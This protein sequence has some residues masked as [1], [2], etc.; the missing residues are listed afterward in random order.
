MKKQKSYFILIGAVFVITV[1]LC[2]V[3]FAQGVTATWS[4]S[5]TFSGGSSAT[6]MIV[7]DSGPIRPGDFTGIDQN[8]L[9]SATTMVVEITL[10]QV[11]TG[12]ASTNY[13]IVAEA[14]AEG[15]GGDSI[16]YSGTEITTTAATRKVKI[17]VALDD[18]YDYD[19]DGN[20]ITTDDKIRDILSRITIRNNGSRAVT[21]DSITVTIDDSGDPIPEPATVAGLL[22]SGLAVAARKKIFL[23]HF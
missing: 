9:D 3:S 7:S 4:G 6:M 21:V 11:T 1:M 17:S 12:I 15:S 18:G 14:N 5:Q 10:S 20:F 19:D 23:S 16:N 8:I 13:T 22:L 2:G